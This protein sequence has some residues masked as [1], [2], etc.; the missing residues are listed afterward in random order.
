MF[1]YF[2]ILEDGSVSF[3]CVRLSRLLSFLD[4]RGL[5][6]RFYGVIFPF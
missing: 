3:G 2:V 1:L 5:F 6:G 4:L